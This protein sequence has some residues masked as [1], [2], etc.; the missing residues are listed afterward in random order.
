[1]NIEITDNLQ[2]FLDNPDNQILINRNAFEKLYEKLNKS[3]YGSAIDVLLFTKL[4]QEAGLNPLEHMYNIPDYFLFEDKDLYAVAVP[5][6]IRRIADNAF[7]YCVNLRSLSFKNCDALTRIGCQ[8]F[9]KCKRL[10]SI[11][12][13]KN[14][15]DIDDFAFK[16]CEGL[17]T[18][19]LSDNIENMGL[20][21]FTNCVNLR[22]IQYDGTIDHWNCIY[23]G[24]HC[25]FNIHEYAKVFCKD[26]V[27]ELNKNK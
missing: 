6:H 27:I 21:S 10:H 20:G 11:E 14:L 19:Y 8:S 25:F 4:I 9:I 5:E 13:P 23:T 3:G 22:S 7:A 15:R 26:G 12:F 17:E 1:M 16:N 18:I 24:P 2:A